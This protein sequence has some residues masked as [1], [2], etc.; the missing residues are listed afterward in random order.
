[1]ARKYMVM[2]GNG[3]E[4][5]RIQVVSDQ[6]KVLFGTLEEAE[7]VFKACVQE[8]GDAQGVT[9]YRVRPMKRAMKSALKGQV[10]VQGELELGTEGGAHDH[11]Q[12]PE[13]APEQAP[14]RRRRTRGQEPAQDTG[15]EQGE[16][17]AVGA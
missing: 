12:A 8:L 16:L 2:L 6:G 4:S 3:E 9:L 14:S 7:E 5:D 13:Q 10:V 15:A 1:M 11:A 17:V